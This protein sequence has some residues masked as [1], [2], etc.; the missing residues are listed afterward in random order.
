[1]NLTIT[2]ES[3]DKA[4]PG[5]Y[6]FDSKLYKGHCLQCGKRYECHLELSD[7]CSRSCQNKFLR[8]LT[9]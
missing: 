8:L 7:F 5:Y 9:V 1:M 6:I 4:Y 2:D 3:F